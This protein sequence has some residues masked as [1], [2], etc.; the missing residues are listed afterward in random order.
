MLQYCDGSLCRS[1]IC[2]DSFDMLASNRQHR[3]AVWLERALVAGRLGQWDAAEQ[4][5][6]ISAKHGTR[7]RVWKLL[8]RIYLE[9]DMLP[10]AL[11]AADKL[12]QP[13]LRADVDELGLIDLTDPRIVPRAVTV[14]IR[15]LV[16]RHGLVAFRSA[17]GDLLAKLPASP[18]EQVCG[19][20]R[21]GLLRTFHT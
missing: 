9:R 3:C 6:R 7:T 13:I 8:L 2:F 14:A 16:A 15:R 11:V 18:S 19:R 1:C 5:A 21:N 12:L 10:E 17:V 4:A 20:K